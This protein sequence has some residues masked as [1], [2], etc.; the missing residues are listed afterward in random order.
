[1]S[2]PVLD[3]AANVGLQLLDAVVMA[4]AEQVILDER[5]K[6]FDLVEPAGIGRG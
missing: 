1:M 2:V 4:A 5:E 3:P 6:P